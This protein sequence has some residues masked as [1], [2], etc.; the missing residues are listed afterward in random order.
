MADQQVAHPQTS[1][2]SSDTLIVG[3]RALVSRAEGPYLTDRRPRSDDGRSRIQG[4]LALTG[5]GPSEDDRAMEHEVR[6]TGRGW[7]KR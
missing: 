5:S 4:P 1:S 6:A 2:V 7:W 3:R